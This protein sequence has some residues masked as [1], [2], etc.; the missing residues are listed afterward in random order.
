MKKTFAGLIAL[1]ATAAVAFGGLTAAADSS[2]KAKAPV[3][4]PVAAAAAPAVSAAPKVVYLTFDDGPDKTWTPKVLGVLAKHK[5]KATFFVLGRNSKSQPTLLR[6]ERAAGH[7]I[8]NHSVTH[9]NLPKL[10]RT[11]LRQEI[12]GGVRSKCFR[13]PYGA[14]NAR[15]HAEIKAAGMRQ[16]LWSVDPQDWARPGATK[17]AQR[18]LSNVRPGAVVLMH[19]AGGNRAQTVI[20]LDKVI[21]TLKARG[22]VFRSL[23]C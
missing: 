19:D 6:K 18:V 7:T 21:R 23:S 13:P 12:R 4:P 9:A 5:V 14:T 22:Y 11:R 3:A 15:V 17:I 2:A 20:A 10:S 8:G 1:T 16:V